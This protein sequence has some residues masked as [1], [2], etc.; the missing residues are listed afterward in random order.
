MAEIRKVAVIGA[1]VMGAGIAAHV[2]NA[3]VPAVLLDIVPSDAKDR[4]AIAKGAL[5]KLEKAKPAAFMKRSAAKLVTPG[6]IEDHLD[7]LADC[8]WIIEAVT[9]QLDIKHAIY[10][11]ID[12]HRKPGSIVSSNTST[13][14]L[15]MLTSGMGEAFAADF[16]V[17]HFFNPPRYMQ[18]LELVASPSTRPE[19]VETIAA[20]CDRALG[21][22][23][24]RCND[25]PGFIGN[26]LG[27]YW[28]LAAINTAF[29]LGLTVEEADAV[30][31]RPFGIPKTGIFGMTDLVGLD[32][33]PLVAKS[34]SGALEAEDAFQAQLRP[35]PLMKRMIETGYTGRK[36][37]GGFYRINRAKGKLKEAIDLE[38]GAYRPSVKPDISV[39][40]DAKRNLLALLDDD[41]RFGRYAWRVMADTLSYAATLV[42]DA[43]DRIEAIDEAMRLGYN[44]TYGPFQLIDRIGVAAFVERLEADGRDVPALL[45]AADGRPFYRIVAGK[46]QGLRAG[47]YEDLAQPADVLLL[48]DI[49]HASS[50]VRTWD[51][52]AL[53]DFGDGV[54]C[55]EITT[56]MNAVDRE[57]LAALD[58][59]LE[60]VGR[61]FR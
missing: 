4:S 21:K 22:G 56:H 46:R 27:V 26:R 8:D 35:Q 28:G 3:G 53:W 43:A 55:F 19:A 39:L 31:G 52:A 6:N 48:E 44:W 42:G 33:F 61:D 14:P 32:L 10:A 11:K 57:V 7:L 29:D 9:E 38:S 49:K 20:F 1:G 25:R 51:A 40:K 54:A 60:I 13:I 2:A 15:A 41:S 59:S 18:L 17:T 37:K 23:V 5:A 16:L 12:A 45:R 47:G 34:L 24:V 30:M 50:P 36:G 58:E